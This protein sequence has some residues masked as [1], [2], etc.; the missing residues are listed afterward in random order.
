MS[1]SVAYPTSKPLFSM[2]D[3]ELNK[4]LQWDCAATR[5]PVKL[6]LEGR[7]IS[8]NASMYELLINRSKA[9]M[10]SLSSAFTSLLL[11]HK[12]QTFEFS[13]PLHSSLPLHLIGG[14][15]GPQNRSP[16]SA[17]GTSAKIALVGTLKIS[18][19]FSAVGI[20]DQQLSELICCVILCNLVL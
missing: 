13:F 6:L 15:S 18:V 17:N 10:V 12:N 3:S 16:W 5:V 20:R 11:V 8:F 7:R 1:F 2:A 19:V 4:R 9:V 14:A